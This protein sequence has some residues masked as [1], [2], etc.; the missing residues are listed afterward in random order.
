MKKIALGMFLAILLFALPQT[1]STSPG[2]EGAY[3]FLGWW[4]YDNYGFTGWHDPGTGTVG[5]SGSGDGQFNMPR[6]AAVDSDGNVYVADTSNN[7]IQK[8]SSSGSFIT[9]WG[10]YGSG[11]GQF[12]SP[13]GV[14]VDSDNNVYVA[15]TSNHRIQKF[16]S[17]GGFF[18]WIGLDNEYNTGWHDP[19]TETY[20]LFGTGDGQ[21]WLPYDV[22]VDSDGNIYVADT[23][24]HRI[25]KFDS[26]GLFLGWW[27]YDNYGLTG[28]HNPES[29][30]IGDDGSGDGQ[31]KY[32]RGIVVD[33]DGNVYVADT[34]NHRIQKFDSFGDLLGWWGYDSLGLTGWHDP[35]T[36]TIGASGSG[37]GQFRSPWG[38]SVDSDGNVYVADMQNYR[39]QKFDSSG[40]L[41]GWWGYDNLG[42][43]GWHLPGTGAYGNFNIEDGQ[44]WLPYD[45]TVDLDDNVFVVDTFNRRIQ[46]F[47]LVPPLE[48]TSPN[49]G[50]ILLAN[51]THDITWETGVG[52][53]YVKIEFSHNNGTDWEEVEASTENDGLYEGWT[54]PCNLSA[55]CLIRITG[56][57]D[58][59]PD[60]S[61]DIFSIESSTPPVITLIGLPEIILE[62]GIGTYEEPG[63]TAEDGC[64]NDVPVVI[65]GD[66]VDT[67]SCDI[68]IITY[69]AIDLSGQAATQVTRTVIVRDTTPPNPD[70]DPLP[71]LEGECSVEITTAPTATDSCVGA[72]EGTTNGTLPITFTEK[73]PHTV[74]WIYDDGNGNT[75]EQIQTVNVIDVTP[76]VPD[77]DPLPI[78]EG[79]CSVEITTAPTATDNCVEGQIIGITEGTLPITFTEQGTHTVIW[80]YNDGNGNIT[81]Q[82]QTVKVED[83]T[84]PTIHLSDSTCVDISK[85][86]I[87]NMLTVSASDN[88]ASD[89]EL[90]IDKV[91]IL[92]KGGRRVWGRGIHRV[93]GND[94]YVFPNG[95]DWS[96]VVTVTASDSNGNTT[97]DSISKPLQQCNRWSAKMARLIRL[98]YMLLWKWHRCW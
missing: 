92:N 49:G 78:L 54:V 29:G 67:M 5:A 18:G 93:V 87:A 22:A 4:G 60:V 57:N 20:G 76:P 80:K 11:D 13:W 56:L 79:E 23:Y 8:F 28:W 37:D 55:E 64:G 26:S 48:V 1:V 21:F 45:V 69:D 38:V 6:S 71:T 61:D 63:A 24:S 81:E 33:S 84:P 2:S 68:Y 58:L 89:V 39:F 44:F 40:G 85:Y 72:I 82:T 9:K 86:K 30:T 73:G 47:D 62:C 16:D 7:R 34:S 10:S 46:K 97:T 88:C 91:K 17:N 35:G 15:D 66:A 75:T 27:G 3:V 90:V 50:E 96:I 25:Q 51:T 74:T 14:C 53:D 31:F 70:V 32:P 36:G 65:K 19:G 41:F 59:I 98:I 43:T 52:N 12:R 77:V 95:R 83:V 42:L 94:I